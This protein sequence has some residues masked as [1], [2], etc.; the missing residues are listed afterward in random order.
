MSSKQKRLGSLAD[1]YQSKNLDGTITRIP[2][3]KIHPSAEQPRQDRTLGVDELARSIE[4]DGLLNPIVVTRDGEGYRIIAGE[5]RF[6]AMKLLKK[7]DAECRII[8]R[9]ERDYYR[10]SIIENLQRE[11]LSAEEEAQALYRLKLQES[12]S[13]QELATIVG[14]SRNYITEILGIA[15]LPGNVLSQCREAGIDN[16]NMM[17]QVVQAHKKGS[18]D[19]FLDAY[20]SGEI[21][22]V[23]AA[24]SF[25]QEDPRRDNENPPGAV[26]KEEPRKNPGVA[27][28]QS[29]SRSVKVH[30][31]IVEIQCHDPEDAA[32]VARWLEKNLPRI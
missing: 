8:S 7:S 21:R 9:E 30:K 26:A 3:E 24:R 25:L 19:S 27:S 10:I 23:R 13:D 20:R 2:L 12:Y 31:Q 18:L 5:R 1:I 28:S 15:A 4:T 17:I 32:R 14:K 22:T 11:D 6:H 16:K 29:G